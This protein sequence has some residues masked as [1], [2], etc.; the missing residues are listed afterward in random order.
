MPFYGSVRRL[1]ISFAKRTR[2]GYLVHRVTCPYWTWQRCFAPA[3]LAG[4]AQPNSPP[5]G[6]PV[7]L[8][9]HH[10]A[11]GDP[12]RPNEGQ[13]S[14]IKPRAPP[15]PPRLPHTWTNSPIPFTCARRAP[16]DA[17]SACRHAGASPACRRFQPA[18]PP[19]IKPNQA[20]RPT[21]PVQ[22]APYLDK[23]AHRLP[24]GLQPAMGVQRHAG[25]SPACRHA[26]ATSRCPRSK[27]AMGCKLCL[28][29]WPHGG[30]DFAFTFG[31]G[32]ALS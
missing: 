10:P 24:C 27:S 29:C 28:P 30:K 12:S 25:A 17:S 5:G 13:S 14:Q 11:P 4:P 7:L 9:S 20:S 1:H 21:F 19:A 16:W 3:C 2:R 8:P 22:P 6:N 15:S 18:I 32:S 23:F 31:T 26:G